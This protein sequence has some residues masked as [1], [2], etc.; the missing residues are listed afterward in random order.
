MSWHYSQALEAAF[1]EAS[2]LDGERSA[3][4]RSTG[5]DGAAYLPARTTGALSPSLSGMT[6][7]LSTDCHGVA[8]LTW[9]LEAIPA[10]RIQP[11]LEAATRLMTF[12]RKCGESWQRSL[13][14][15]YLRRTFHA[16][17]LTPQQT[18]S[19]RWAIKPAAFPFPR[20]TWVQ[21]TSGPGIGYVHTP[22]TKANYAAKSMQK[23]P[24][25]RAFVQAFGRPSPEV[26]E[27]LM[28]WPSGWSDTKPLAKGNYRSWQ[29]RHGAC[30]E[31]R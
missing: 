4:S 30:C 23:W 5:T 9:C 13:P 26:H 11:R 27:W 2:S 12:G 15:A 8:V 28:A 7:A 1:S 29:Q 18:T 10:K 24:S 19:K 22:T 25:C 21:I 31:P 17:P 6:S 3:Q 20:R 14:G 16:G